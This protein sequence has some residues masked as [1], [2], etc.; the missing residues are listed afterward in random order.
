MNYLRLIRDHWPLL[1]VVPTLVTLVT[2]FGTKSIEPNYASSATLVVLN[3]PAQN[4]NEPTVVPEDP[5]NP[6]TPALNPAGPGS[7][8]DLIVADR[9]ISTYL[10]LVKR[11]PVLEQAAASLEFTGTIEALAGKVSVVSP[12]NTQLIVVSAEDPNPEVAAAIANAITEAFIQRSELQIANA[13]TLA[14]VEPATAPSSPFSPNLKLNLALALALS[15][16]GA[17][18]LAIILERLNSPVR[19]ARDILE[20]SQ[21][22]TL[23]TIPSASESTWAHAWEDSA[24]SAWADAFRKVRASLSTSGFGSRYRSLL[25]TSQKPGAG[26]SLLAANLAIAFANAGQRVLLID[27]DLTQPTQHEYFGLPNDHGIAEITRPGKP[28]ALPAKQ[29]D[30]A[31]LSLVAAGHFATNPEDALAPGLPEHF[32]Q[33]AQ[34]AFD[35]LIVDGPSLSQSS[36]ASVL[37]SSLDASLLVVVGGSTTQAELRTAVTELTSSHAILVG[38]VINR[39]GRPHPFRTRAHSHAVSRLGRTPHG[40]NQDLLGHEVN[41]EPL[42]PET[43]A[44]SVTRQP[45]AGSEGNIAT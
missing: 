13:G 1:I 20:V 17:A 11:R 12:S 42:A 8:S 44:R 19:T 35:L 5:A 34:E 45:A 4:S 36:S 21:V 3:Q 26:K 37:S 23:G 43:R 31:N 10:E 15:L 32:L 28:I 27:L 7:L 9:L 40:E 29:T 14:L 39:S 16:A 30:F 33:R 24:N 18:T 22:Q 2:Y 41:P 6:N 25:I 38:A